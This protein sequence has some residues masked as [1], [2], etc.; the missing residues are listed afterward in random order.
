VDP[1]ASDV[2]PALVGIQ[3]LQDDLAVRR[4]GHRAARDDAPV[5]HRDRR[6]DERLH[7]GVAEAHPAA[8]DGQ[9]LGE[10][11]AARAGGRGR[12]AGGA[13]RRD[14]AEHGDEN[15]SIAREGRHG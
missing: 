15:D 7:A 4:A 13:Q 14:R 3:T 12:G 6:H 8:G 2:A 1:R 9:D 10:R 5:E 11:G